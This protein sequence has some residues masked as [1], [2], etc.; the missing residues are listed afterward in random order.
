[1]IESLKIQN[2]QAHA[3]L[4]LKLDA[5]T[6]ITG[7]SDVGKSA[8]IRALRWVSQNQPAGDAFLKD[9]TEGVSVRL[10]VDGHE[11]CRRR[12]KGKN[13]Y[14]LDGDVFKA[15][16]NEV[17]EPIRDVLRIGPENFQQQHDA[18]F[19]LS[20]SAG[21]VSKKLNEV[22][23]LD[24]IDSALSFLDKEVR[25]RKAE[26]KVGTQRLTEAET[27]VGR[28]N[29]VLEA[30]EDADAVQAA[31]Q[32]KLTEYRSAV[33]LAEHVKR[34]RDLRD[35][36]HAVRQ[37]LK[38]L[39]SLGKAA[40]DWADAEQQH[41]QLAN[42]VQ[43][44]VRFR[45]KAARKLPAAAEYTKIEKLD[46]QAGLVEIANLRAQLRTAKTYK[47]RIEQKKSELSDVEVE[48][49]SLTK[50]KCPLCGADFDE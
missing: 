32:L 8:I 24:V 37:R 33:G 47:D 49:H 11:I 16:G 15:F 10:T 25:Q 12:S 31:E 44:A 42:L 22:V 30:K 39:Q 6:S 14:L 46:Y 4:T 40:K 23:D 36:R 1:M 3:K 5:V 34:V 27:Q 28:L 41:Q 29:W 9:G 20:L 35:G 43:S 17:P 19:W 2:F 18:P 48:L 26:C 7:P 50:G 21:E 38:S 13:E 45:R